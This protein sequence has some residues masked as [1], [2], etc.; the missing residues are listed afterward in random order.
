MHFP[1]HLFGLRKKQVIK[2]VGFASVYCHY[3][4]SKYGCQWGSLA[5]LVQARRLV[6][7]NHRARPS[8]LQTRLSGGAD[9]DTRQLR[10]KKNRTAPDGLRLTVTLFTAL[11]SPG[12]VGDE[13]GSSGGVEFPVAG[14][15]RD[16]LQRQTSS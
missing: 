9:S 13:S 12:A 2:P 11:Q 5:G 10:G 6:S 4:E 14:W 8:A 3:K 1:G 7:Q 16:P 15:A